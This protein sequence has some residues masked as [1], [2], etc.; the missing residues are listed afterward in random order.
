MKFIKLKTGAI[1]CILSS[2]DMK[3]HGL[4]IKDFMEQNEQA[5]EFMHTL[6]ERAMVETGYV[7]KPGMISLKVMQISGERLSITISEGAPEEAAFK[8]KILDAFLKKFSLMD[9]LAEDLEEEE[10]ELPKENGR[11]DAIFKRMLKTGRETIFIVFASLDEVAAFSSAILYGRPISSDL[12]KTE[13]DYVLVIKKDAMSDV[14]FTRISFLGVEFK[15][16]FLYDS[17]AIRVLEHGDC[18]IKN[19]AISV[20]KKI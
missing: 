16:R 7:A 8:E 2:E 20:M 5:T 15:G 18:L 12:Y 11:K 4:Q 10:D 3:E 17:E 1:R 19:K 14:S 9:D 13:Q 6:I